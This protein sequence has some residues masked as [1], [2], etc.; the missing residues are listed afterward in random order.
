VF[1]WVMVLK[2]MICR[3]S[4]GRRHLWYHD[5]TKRSARPRTCCSR[6]RNCHYWAR[7]NWV[8]NGRTI[9]CQ[10]SRCWAFNSPRL[11]WGGVA[12]ERSEDRLILAAIVFNP[13]ILSA[14]HIA[15]SLLPTNDTFPGQALAKM[16]SRTLVVSFL[17]DS[18]WPMTNV[19]PTFVGISL[20]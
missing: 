5:T 13:L 19:G 4:F 1:L 9:P 15:T 10:K 7:N 14:F 18:S 2:C 12:I 17:G 8:P 11:S 20:L 6:M 3:T 16:L